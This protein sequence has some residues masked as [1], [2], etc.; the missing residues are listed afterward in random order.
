MKF[1]FKVV[2]GR[3]DCSKD[4]VVLQRVEASILGHVY[5]RVRVAIARPS[6]SFS[7]EYSESRMPRASNYVYEVYH[8]AFEDEEGA[9]FSDDSLYDSPD[10]F[11]CRFQIESASKEYRRV[12]YAN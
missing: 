8:A 4:G 6:R 2:D 12:Q 11:P 10:A 1:R 7:L 9:E 5:N 3:A